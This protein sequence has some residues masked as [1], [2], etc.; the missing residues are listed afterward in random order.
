MNAR[1]MRS[2]ALLPFLFTFAAL[3]FWVFHYGSH[4]P[5]RDGFIYLRKLDE[6]SDGKLSISNLLTSRDNQHPIAFQI[7]IAL[8]FLKVFPGSIWSIVVGNA[9]MLWLSAVVLYVTAAQS[10]ASRKQKFLLACFI[11]ASTL[12]G[13]QASSLL[14]EFQ[15]WFYCN[16]LLLALNLLLTERYG[17]RAYPIVALFCLFATGNEAQGAFLW[18]VA[19]AHMLYVTSTNVKRNVRIAGVVILAAHVM[20]FLA[21]AWTLSHLQYGGAP[22]VDAN[23]TLPGRLIFSVQLLGG[24][25]GVKD[26]SIAFV[27]GLMSLLA[28]GVGTFFAAC[29]KFALMIDRVAFLICGVSLMWTAAFAMARASFGIAWALSEF[30]GSLMMIPLYAGIGMYATSMLAET[31]LGWRVAA[32]CLS[33]FTLSPVLTG[34]H[35]ARQQSVLLKVNSLL[36]AAVECTNVSVPAALK[37]NL[38]GLRTN[39][40]IYAEIDRHRSELCGVQPNL[41]RAVEALKIPPYYAEQISKDPRVGDALQALWYQYLSRQDLREAYPLSDPHLAHDLLKWGAVE[42]ATATS[43]DEQALAQYATTL[44]MLVEQLDGSPS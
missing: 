42:A 27:F 36:A 21:L 4:W 34:M 9:A 39:D 30:H 5:Y 38:S 1:L 28:W 13:S 6:L 16:L 25:F 41:S 32:L 18:L 15:I 2:P 20:I 14:W 19:A 31:A 43:G 35:F 8:L 3:A 11:C 22:S 29:R 44:K 24:G 26:P 12:T 37:Q 10:L 23:P 17:L 33:A 40:D 7:V